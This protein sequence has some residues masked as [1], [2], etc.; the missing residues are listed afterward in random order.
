MLYT[1]IIFNKLQVTAQPL[2]RHQAFQEFLNF[3]TCLTPSS[4]LASFNTF[5]GETFR[6]KRH[7]LFLSHIELSLRFFFFFG[8][9]I[10]F[11][12]TEK[13]TIRDNFLLVFGF[14]T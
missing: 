5:A 3:I 6:K 9:Q 8:I 4:V 7:S 14:L 10:S 12:H 13:D 2:G 1:T 11:N